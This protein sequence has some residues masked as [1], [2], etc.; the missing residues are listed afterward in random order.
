MRNLSILKKD[1]T[2]EIFNIWPNLSVIDKVND[3]LAHYVQW[4]IYNCDL[5]ENHYIIYIPSFNC[6]RTLKEGMYLCN[7]LTEP[8]HY[9]HM[10][11]FISG[12][13]LHSTI[14][15]NSANPKIKNIRLSLFKPGSSTNN[16]HEF[17]LTSNISLNRLN[18]FYRIVYVVN[19]L[20]AIDYDQFKS[21]FT[22]ILTII[23]S[24]ALLYPL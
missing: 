21:E 23:K 18:R 8:D 9:I 11:P 6:N 12:L 13:Y 15:R 22:N 7:D 1:I 3:P 10:F 16:K 2:N 19:K 24:E 17:Y 20:F 5:Q 4:N 14:V